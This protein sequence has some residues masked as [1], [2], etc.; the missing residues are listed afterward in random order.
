MRKAKKMSVRKDAT[1]SETKEIASRLFLSPLEKR[2]RPSSRPK[3]SRNF[4]PGYE[5]NPTICEDDN[6]AKQFAPNHRR[7]ALRKKL[8]PT[9]GEIKIPGITGPQ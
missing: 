7:K 9:I 1:F 3:K 4:R 2:P 8:A 6:S 5:Y